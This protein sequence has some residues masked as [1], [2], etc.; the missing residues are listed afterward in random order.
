MHLSK[1]EEYSQA[2]YVR[3]MLKAEEQKNNNKKNYE[4]EHTKQIKLQNLKNKQKKELEGLRSRLQALFDEE[5]EK[6]NQEFRTL[7]VRLR[8]LTSKY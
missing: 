3:K 6:K 5:I 8:I 2:S 4:C 7:T 1:N